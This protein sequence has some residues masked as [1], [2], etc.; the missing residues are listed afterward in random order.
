[1]LLSMGGR[2]LRLNGRNWLHLWEKLRGLYC[3]PAWTAYTF[4]N[5]A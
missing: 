4:N 1:M 2:R 5:Y 3:L